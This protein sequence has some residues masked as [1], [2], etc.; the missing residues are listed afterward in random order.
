MNKNQADYYFG[1]LVRSN[2]DLVHLLQLGGASIAMLRLSDF[3]TNYDYLTAALLASKIIAIYA[4]S[5]LLDAIPSRI[6]VYK[7]TKEIK[8]NKEKYPLE[9]AE[10]IIFEDKQGLEMLLERTARKEKTEWGTFLKA[11]EDNGTAVIDEI[12]DIE[13][14][15]RIGLIG[16]GTRFL[17]GIDSDKAKGRYNGSHHYHCQ[18]E[19]ATFGINLY[20]KN[21]PENWINLITFNVDGEPEIVGYNTLYTYIPKNKIK[22]D[23]LVK[24]NPKMI[25]EYLS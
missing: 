17:A 25:M 14:G 20:E 12:L 18:T 21:S 4:G 2:I 8:K 13:E 19:S 3:P 23:E 1:R 22:K 9:H 10:K 24:A 16:K 15:K 6:S 5:Q 11:H 7:K